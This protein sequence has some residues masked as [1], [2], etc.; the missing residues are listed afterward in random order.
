M[1]KSINQVTLV[2]NVGADPEIRSL[3]SGIRCATLTLATS[4]SWT[5]KG[6]ERQEKT[7]WHKLVAFG[8]QGSDGLAGVIEKYVKKGD[9]L[10]V[11]GSVE[12]RQWE[13]QEGAKRY[14]TEIKVKEL[15]LLASRPPTGSMP[16]AAP[17]RASEQKSR[18][19]AQ[20]AKKSRVVEQVPSCPNCQGEMYDNRENKKN[21]AGPDWRC[22]D[23]SC[24]QEGYT[25]ALWEKNRGELWTVEED[26]STAWVTDGEPAAPRPRRAAQAAKASKKLVP[27]ETEDFQDFPGALEDDDDD[28]P[29]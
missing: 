25:T 3:S 14:S 16:N 10:Y 18:G 23:K 12:Y 27:E 22:K 29:F 19:K 28:L 9:K 8:R 2:G 11:S 4:E 21:P 7:Q 5:P 20:P 17:A 15:V 26:G 6:G 1:G 13:D 24:T